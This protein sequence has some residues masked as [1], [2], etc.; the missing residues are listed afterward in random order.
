MRSFFLYI[1]AEIPI[2][3]IAVYISA[4]N[5]YIRESYPDHL[6]GYPWNTES[7]ENRVAGWVGMSWKVL[8]L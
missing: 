4:V 7:M 5:D 8:V 6:I 3:I 2:N 1:P